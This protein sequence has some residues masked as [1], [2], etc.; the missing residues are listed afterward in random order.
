MAR[1]VIT[2]RS[3]RLRS[4]VPLRTRPILSPLRNEFVGHGVKT[5]SAGRTALSRGH[6]RHHAPSASSSLR[7]ACA[8]SACPSRARWSSAGYGYLT[9]RSGPGLYNLAW[10]R[11]APRVHRCRLRPRPMIGEGS[12]HCG[13]ESTVQPSRRWKKRL[14]SSPPVSQ[15]DRATWTIRRPRCLARRLD[16]IDRD[17]GTAGNASSTWPSSRR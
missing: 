8:R 1:P 16:R 4:P 5:T 7:R 2:W 14:G 15:Y 10:R 17:R 3:A 11:L 6:P 13:R 9:R 12:R